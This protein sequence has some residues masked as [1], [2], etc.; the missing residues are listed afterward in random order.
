MIVAAVSGGVLRIS[1]CRRPVE[2]MEAGDS[3]LVKRICHSGSGS[4]DIFSVWWLKP[5]VSI[6]M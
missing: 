4:S 6:R 3:F 5:M 1:S 2:G